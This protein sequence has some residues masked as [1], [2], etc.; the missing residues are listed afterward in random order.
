MMGKAN[1]L[2]FTYLCIPDSVFLSAACKLV[3]EVSQFAH[4]P[5]NQKSF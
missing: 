3:S 4:G 1:L 5:I 2:Q